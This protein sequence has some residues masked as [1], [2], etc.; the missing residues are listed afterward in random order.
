MVSN[1]SQRGGMER[2]EPPIVVDPRWLLRAGLVMLAVA[3]VCGYVTLCWLFYQGQWQLVLHPVKTMD[4]P[5]AVGGAP[6]EVVR[7]GPDGSGIPQRTAWWMPP[8]DADPYRHLVVLYLP[9]GDGSLQD[10]VPR[11]EG[12]RRLGIA[13]FAI[14]YRGYGESAAVNPNEVRM[15][16]DAEAAWSYLVKE[17]RVS[18][19]DVIPYGTGVGASLALDLVQAHPETAAVVLDAPRFDVLARV[20]ADP[21]VRFLPVDRLLHDRFA[22]EPALAQSKVPKLIISKAAMETGEIAGAGDP[23]MTVEMAGFDQGLFDQALRR[24]LDAYAPPTPA[25]QL[26]PHGAAESAK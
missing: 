2:E 23:K 4:R 18:G 14:N 16:E 17:R 24:F 10:A 11:L 20:K 12:L 3:F 21:R 19:A 22:M 1:G 9:S 13:V 6:Y 5:A 8:R 25:V 26:L 7:F 15:R